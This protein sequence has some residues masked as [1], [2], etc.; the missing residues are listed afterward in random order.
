M[1]TWLYV[2][3]TVAALYAAV[4]VGVSFVAWWGMR[5][6]AHK[7]ELRRLATPVAHP[8][9]KVNDNKYTDFGPR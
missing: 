1:N 7:A 4:L 3:L 5:L 6:E 2:L 8:P 9:E